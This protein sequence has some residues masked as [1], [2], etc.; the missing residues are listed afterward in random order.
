VIKPEPVSMLIIDDNENFLNTISAYLL[1]HHAGEIHVLGT[2]RSGKEGINL[3]R[4]LRPQAVL[5][6]LKMPEMHG[7]DVVPLLR[8]VLPEIK[9]ITTTLLS[10]EAFEQAGEIYAQASSSAGADGFIPKYNLT[11]QLIPAIQKMMQST[12][13]REVTP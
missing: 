11:T 3:A 13:P 9:I 10:P 6:D 4:Q 2:A 1:E 7:F 8:E 12:R 5:L